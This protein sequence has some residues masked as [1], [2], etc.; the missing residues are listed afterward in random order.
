MKSVIIGAGLAALAA[1]GLAPVASATTADVAVNELRAQGYL[2]QINQTP[3]A[4][5]TACAVKNVSTLA[6]GDAPS[7]IVDIACPDG[8]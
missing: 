6:G 1:V 5:L 8:C 4:P 7:A 2:V 3:T